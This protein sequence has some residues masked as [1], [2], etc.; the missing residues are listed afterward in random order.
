MTDP[1]RRLL[2]LIVDRSGSMEPH[3]EDAEGGLRAFLAEQRKVPG[4]TSVTLRE[5]DNVCATVYENKLL[6]EVP[7]Y[8][9]VPRY[10]TALLDAVGM[11]IV[12]V[13]EQLAA[14]DEAD[15]PGEVIMMIFTDGKENVSKKYKDPDRVNKMISHQREKYGWVVGFLGADQDAIK[16]AGEM[17]IGPGTALSYNSSN[18][19]ASMAVASVMVTRGSTSGVYGFTADERAAATK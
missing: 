5:F 6:S 1:N 4:V 17:G 3:R 16:V 13:G 11:T 2:V 12:R 19:E 7:D 15:R 10:G 18:T 9:L 14:M 8:E